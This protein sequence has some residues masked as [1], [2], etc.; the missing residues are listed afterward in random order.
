MA[1]KRSV[2]T[3]RSSSLSPDSDEEREHKRFRS[4][5]PEEHS[6]DSH[7]SLKVYVVQEKI[8][9]N[10]L[11]ELFDSIESTAK[12]SSFLLEPVSDYRGADIIVTN[13][14]MRKRLERHVPWNVAVS[15]LRLTSTASHLAHYLV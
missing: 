1:P 11:V 9:E 4:S 3:R 15:G 7:R 8:E 2:A 12:T 14:H 5:S 10:H 13:I 6:W